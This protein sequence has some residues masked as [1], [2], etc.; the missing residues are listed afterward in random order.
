MNTFSSIGSFLTRGSNKPR[1]VQISS[2]VTTAKFTDESGTYTQYYFLSTSGPNYIQLN[3]FKTTKTIS[4]LC[5]GGGGGGANA[6]GGG[7]AGGFREYSLTL[8]PALYSSERI[9]CV[10]GAGGLG[11]P[12]LQ[13]IYSVA[14]SGG[15]T[16]V[17][18]QNNTMHT[19]ESKGGGGGGGRS[20]SGSN[21]ASGGGSM[22]AGTSLSSAE[23]S[24]GEFGNPGGN[25]SSS[26]WQSGSGGGGAGG[27]GG[28]SL[29]G[30][31][32]D[33]RGGPGGIGKQC[34]LNGISKTLYWAGG[35]G[36]MGQ[37]YNTSNRNRGGRGGGGGGWTGESNGETNK[38]MWSIGGGD[39]FRSVVSGTGDAGAN[40]GSGGGGMYYNGR[41]QGD[42]NDYRGGH[43]ADGIVI[44]S[45]KDE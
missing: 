2:Q 3:N 37:T 11:A 33:T 19:K 6:G 14:S 9:T 35:G 43:G 21:G 7:G 18:F 4:I 29:F 40:T 42:P 22:E 1:E 13:S 31:P 26:N 27:A 39:A 24:T 10:V 36:G 25:A 23:T 34:S 20:T 5:I 15:S 8:D 44:I 38:K 12:M 16:T 30:N 28:D 41:K 17:T 45:I 32:D